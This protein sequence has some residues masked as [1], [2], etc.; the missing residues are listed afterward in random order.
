MTPLSI[1]TLAYS[2]LMSILYPLL[3]RLYENKSSRPDLLRATWSAAAI[4]PLT[5]VQPL[6]VPLL[7]LA[8][9][10]SYRGWR[11]VALAAMIVALIAAA[12]ATD[13]A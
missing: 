7:F 2:L 1:A 9:Y 5:P 3:P 13:T 8:T 10:S 12:L 6:T 11:P 4:L